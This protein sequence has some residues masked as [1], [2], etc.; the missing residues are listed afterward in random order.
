MQMS[1]VVTDIAA[2][3]GRAGDVDLLWSLAQ[4]LATTGP[5]GWGRAAA[6]PV[7][8]TLRHFAADY[9]AHLEGA[10]CPALPARSGEGR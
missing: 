1:E 4:T 8:S 2:G 6:N 7:L 5:C 10:P 9:R 3:R